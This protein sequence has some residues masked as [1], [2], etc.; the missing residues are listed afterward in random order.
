MES[1]EIESKSDHNLDHCDNICCS[2][3]E[4]S[5][6]KDWIQDCVLTRL[7]KRDDESLIEL[8]LKENDNNL[9]QSSSTLTSSSSSCS[10][11]EDETVCSQ[12]SKTKAGCR[13]WLLSNQKWASWDNELKA[14]LKRSPNSK[15]LKMIQSISLGERLLKENENQDLIK[16]KN[17]Y[18][19]NL[20]NFEDDYFILP[21][22]SG[23]NVNHNHESQKLDDSDCNE[24]DIGY[25][26]MD[27]F[28]KSHSLSFSGKFSI[29]DF[30]LQQQQEQHYQ[31][32]QEDIK[33]SE[34]VQDVDLG[35]VSLTDVVRREESLNEE[36][37]TMTSKD[38]KVN[39]KG[40]KTDGNCQNHPHTIYCRPISESSSIGHLSIAS[41]A[42]SDP[43]APMCKI[44][45]LN[46][47]E[48]DP[49]IT[50]CRCAGTMRYIH[51]GCLMVSQLNPKSKFSSAY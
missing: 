26:S 7:P 48:L 45:H 51:C 16:R 47:K 42:T 37:L 34:T 43:N 8:D 27:H 35:T 11:T 20:S 2:K 49:L 5:D 12:V 33:T 1:I 31:Q 9:P 39:S 36:Q 44:C 50:P 4:I 17:E 3:D 13:R 32:Q 24:E 14:K 25:F 28:R 29:G 30:S 21:G 41:S 38:N 15:S 6:K 18:S 22:P 23:L 19:S 46:A 40:L 10:E